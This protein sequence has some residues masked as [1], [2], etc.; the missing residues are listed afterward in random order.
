M[1]SETEQ[2]KNQDLHTADLESRI[3]LIRICFK[4]ERRLFASKQESRY[5]EEF[6]ELELRAGP[7]SKPCRRL[8]KMKISLQTSTHSTFI[9]DGKMRI[10]IIKLSLFTLK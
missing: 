4:Y 5:D 1:T 6:K 2:S 8:V 9:I 3:L 10:K 7:Y